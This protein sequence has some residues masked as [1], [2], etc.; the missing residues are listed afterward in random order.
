MPWI[1][2]KTPITLDFITD[3]RDM[4]FPR[5]IFMNCN[6]KKYVNKLPVCDTLKFNLTQSTSLLLLMKSLGIL[7]MVPFD[8]TSNYIWVLQW[9]LCILY[10]ITYYCRTPMF[11]SNYQKLFYMN[12]RLLKVWYIRYYLDLWKPA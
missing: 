11:V 5:Y 4:Q 1:A 7:K 6:S 2:Y 3:M 8:L 9:M 12:M 10:F